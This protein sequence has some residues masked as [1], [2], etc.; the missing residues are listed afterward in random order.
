MLWNLAPGALCY[1]NPYPDPKGNIQ[2]PW[3]DGEMANKNSFKNWKSSQVSYKSYIP[4]ISF[5]LVYFKQIYI[6]ISGASKAGNLSF[7]AIIHRQWFNHLKLSF[8]KK[9]C[10][11]NP[12][13][14]QTLLPQSGDLLVREAIYTPG[15][16][17][18][19]RACRRIFHHSQAG[20][21]FCC[22]NKILANLEKKLSKKCQ[23]QKHRQ[24]PP[25]LSWNLSFIECWNSE[26]DF[27]C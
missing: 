27:S 2:K 26:R 8:R 19:K 12:D 7:S 16:L 11:S 24:N 21:S 14:H 17:P 10:Q 3:R 22:D 20:E 18:F 5:Q 13:D 6:Y 15:D 25:E 23:T 9:F 1:T 4:S